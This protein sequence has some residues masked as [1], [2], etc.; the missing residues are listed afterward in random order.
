M[1]DWRLR[2][3]MVGSLQ[4]HLLGVVDDAGRKPYG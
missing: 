3:G 2:R 1:A 4:K